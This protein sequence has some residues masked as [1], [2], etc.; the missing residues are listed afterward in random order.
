MVA[1]WHAMRCAALRC[2]A[3]RWMGRRW[4]SRVRPR[5]D[6]GSRNQGDWQHL[7]LDHT[8]EVSGP[9]RTPFPLDRL[10][11]FQPC[12]AQGTWLH[13]AGLLSSRV[14]LNLVHTSP[15]QANPAVRLSWASRTRH[16]WNGSP[17]RNGSRAHAT[18]SHQDE[19]CL[20]RP[21]PPA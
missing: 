18:N 17:S 21:P 20:S 5:A 4:W 3:M 12:A 6:P 1:R 7:D 14:N 2:D 9:M 11:S 16:R 10:L 19:A 13:S 15:V 8:I